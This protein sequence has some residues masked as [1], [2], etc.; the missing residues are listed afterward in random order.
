MP[1]I[2]EDRAGQARRAQ[3]AEINREIDKL[4]KERHLYD[5]SELQDRLAP[6]FAELYRLYQ[7]EFPKEFPTEE[8]DEEFGPPDHRSPWHFDPVANP[9]GAETMTMSGNGLT[10]LGPWWFVQMFLAFLGGEFFLGG[11]AGTVVDADLESCCADDRWK[12]TALTPDVCSVSGGTLHSDG[13]FV[14]GGSVGRLSGPL[15]VT[16]GFVTAHDDTA[17]LWVQSQPGPG[18]GWTFSDTTTG[19]V[20]S[21][22][23]DGGSVLVKVEGVSV[24]TPDVGGTTITLGPDTTAQVVAVQSTPTDVPL[25]ATGQLTV[26]GGSVVVGDPGASVGWDVSTEP[27]TF[28]A[29]GEVVTDPRVQGQLTDFA[30][31]WAIEPQDAAFGLGQLTGWILNG[32]TTMD[33]LNAELDHDL[34]IRGFSPEERK[35][36][37][38]DRQHALGLVF[39]AS[40]LKLQAT[41]VNPAVSSLAGSA[42]PVAPTIAASVGTTKAPTFDIPRPGTSSIDIDEDLAGV[43]Q[44]TL[45]SFLPTLGRDIATFTNDTGVDV[46]DL[47]IVFSDPTATFADKGPFKEEKPPEMHTVAGKG[48]VTRG[49]G[50]GT[51]AN[52]GTGACVMKWKGPSKDPPIQGWW[53]TQDGWF[54]GEATWIFEVPEDDPGSLDVGFGSQIGGGTVTGPAPIGGATTTTGSSNKMTVKGLKNDKGSLK[55][56]DK[57]TVR[58][59]RPQGERAKTP[60][61]PKSVK[62]N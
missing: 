3:I 62:F 41:G 52:K 21:P 33:R 30:S 51:V 7:K 10:D 24:A 37:V 53:W 43:P 42:L 58:A 13:S 61:M 50:N 19:D 25:T 12:S 34:E 2:D 23:P 16:D 20:V 6:L 4:E 17:T 56:G 36:A 31:A 46:N 32:S 40:L 11:R 44:P 9:R 1:P 39:G 59:G 5:E 54:V 8:Q 48:M 35:R 27:S 55:K 18:S 45:A 15:D 28:D 22:P 49:L 47:H 14:S 57:V 60:P 26:S 29:V 38:T